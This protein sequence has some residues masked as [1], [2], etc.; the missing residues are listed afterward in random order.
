MAK[1]QDVPHEIR[2]FNKLF[3]ELEYR[4]HPSEVLS[5]YLDYF[6]YVFNTGRDEAQ[7][8]HIR[9][10]YGKY[11]EVLVR[12]WHEHLA[13]QD[14]MITDDQ[15][16]YDLPGTMYEAIVSRSKSSALGQF[17]TP[18]N[19]CDFMA[20][21]NG[22]DPMVKGKTVNDPACGSGRTLLAW[23]AKAPGNY[24]FGDDLDPMCTKMA[25]V[26]FLLHGCVGQVCNTNSLTLD[27]WRFGYSI[28][29]H[30]NSRGLISLR[31][32]TREESFSYSMWLRKI[33]EPEAKAVETFDVKIDG[34]GQYALF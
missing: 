11:Y 25:A 26:N 21:I 33:E 14:R 30:L 32:I 6:I 10:K 4:F 20:Q 15:S 22:A 27:D 29:E 9:N 13:V 8:E 19:V 2:G 12:M 28:N 34:Q 3:Q 31:P 1:T 7:I 23:H 18:A 5:D 16:W 24:V 17:F